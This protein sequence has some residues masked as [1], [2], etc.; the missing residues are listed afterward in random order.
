[1]LKHLERVLVPLG[2][3]CTLG[4]TLAHAAIYTWTD[5][6]GTINISNLAPPEGARVISVV[7]E[8]PPRIAPP[9]DVAG[10]A[11]RQLEVQALS[12]RVRQLEYEAEFARRPAPP[13]PVYQAFPAVQYSQY[14]ADYGPAASSGCD[15]SWAGCT[16]WWSPYGYPAIVVL[17]S[18][19]FRRSRPIHG[20]PN[21]PMR[22][23]MGSSSVAYR[24]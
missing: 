10:E 15:P 14:P 17:Q 2:L 22:R 8:S 19:N 6:S 5:G 9:T 3:V 16:N 12:D 21:A 20:G 23:P 1:M 7:P 4:V 13:A 18:P 11:A 24:R